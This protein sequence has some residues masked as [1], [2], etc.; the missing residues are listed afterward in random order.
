MTDYRSNG[1]AHRE[2][3]QGKMRQCILTSSRQSHTHHAG[4]TVVD[5]AKAAGVR[6]F[7][8][9]SGTAIS[10]ISGGELSVGSFDGKAEVAEYLKAS[11]LPYKL[12]YPSGFLSTFLSGPLAPKKQEDGTY[13]LSLPMPPT[14]VRP[15][16]DMKHDFGMYVRTLI[17]NPALGPGS[18][19]WAGTALS[20]EDLLKELS[21]C[22]AH[23]LRRFINELI[24]LVA[25]TGR[26]YIYRQISR[27][28]W[29][30]IVAPLKSIPTERPLGDMYYDM[31]RFVERYGCTSNRSQIALI[32]ALD[33]RYHTQT[34]E[35]KTSR[36]ATKRR[37]SSP[38][39]SGRC[40]SR[41]RKPLLECRPWRYQ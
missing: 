6:L 16:V 12:I 7:I 29:D 14:V 19:V 22:E 13:L 15:M 8:W 28:E 20:Y 30:A 31:G 41:I 24:N 38:P 23:S 5:C 40:T 27:E 35:G 34:S 18:E 2:A 39:H 17:E 37:E 21:E 36:R 33:F 3:L 11:G 26:K 10:K 25:V 1:S 32:P 4:P 9:S